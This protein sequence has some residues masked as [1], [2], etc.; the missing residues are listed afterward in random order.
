MLEELFSLRDQV[1]VVTGGTSGIGLSLAGFLM[2]AGARVA[3][4]ARNPE[5][6]R[7][8]AAGL[9]DA[10]GEA[11]FFPADVSRQDQVEAM[12]EAIEKEMGPIDILI[13]SAGINI[14]RKAVEFQLDEWRRVLDVN[15][16]GTYL[17]CR[18]IGSRMIG[19]KKGRVVNISSVASV[20]GLTGRAPYCASKGGVTQL[21][22]VLAIEWAPYGITVNAIGPGYMNTP[23]IADLVK[24]PAF[25][26]RVKAEIP[27]GRVGQTRDLAGMLL[28]L[29][30]GAGAYI[31]GQTIFVDGG[32]TIW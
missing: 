30:S 16:T 32:W 26:N 6:G 24:D 13:N 25:Q 11:A 18:V 9:A 3:V 7:Q 10:G 1:A 28:V 17:P 20:L 2:G 19:R 23:L 21:T 22:K 5:A 29:C 4:V 8:A 31:T 15:L 27:M 12:A 14:R